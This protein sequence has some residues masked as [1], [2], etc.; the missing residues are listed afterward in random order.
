MSEPQQQSTWSTILVWVAFL[1][2]VTLLAAPIGTRLG[3][4]PWSVGLQSLLAVAIGGSV[5]AIIAV[6]TFF[7]ARKP[8]WRR[9][10]APGSDSFRCR[11]I[12][13]SIYVGADPA[14]AH[15]SHDPRHID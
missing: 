8:G 1:V 14:R 12:T 10:P 2:A 15:A 13:G 5:V 9:K 3:L 4:W 7:V 6:I 11:L